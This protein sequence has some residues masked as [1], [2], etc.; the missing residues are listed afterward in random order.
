MSPPQVEYFRRKLLLLRADTRH[1]LAATPH[2]SP[3]DSLREGDQADQASAA[4]DREFSIINRE[5]ATLLLHQID[6]ALV[7]L[8]NGAYGYCEDSGE[9]IDLGRLEVQPTATLS[10]EAQERREKSGG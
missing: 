5:R 4:V 7:R 9:P 1:E 10:I 8:D 3:D 6:Q 2:A